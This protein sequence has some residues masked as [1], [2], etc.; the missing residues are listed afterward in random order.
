MVNFEFSGAYFTIRLI[1]LEE[2]L[3]PLIILLGGVDC[4]QDLLVTINRSKSLINALSALLI[5]SLITKRGLSFL[6]GLF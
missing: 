3:N 2:R 1:L 5:C 6:K 4:M